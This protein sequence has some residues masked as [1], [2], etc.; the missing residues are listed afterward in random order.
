MAEK[1]FLGWGSLEKYTSMLLDG[2]K[3]W[4]GVHLREKRCFKPVRRDGGFEGLTEDN[5]KF[6]L[7]GQMVWGGAVQTMAWQGRGRNMA[8]LFD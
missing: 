4:V 5:S 8:L 3:R 2:G 6:T 1:S 7:V